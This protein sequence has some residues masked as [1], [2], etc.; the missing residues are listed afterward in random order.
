VIASALVCTVKLMNSFA[1]SQHLFDIA[2]TPVD[3]NSKFPS[4]YVTISPNM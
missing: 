1:R 2:A 4:C 3:V